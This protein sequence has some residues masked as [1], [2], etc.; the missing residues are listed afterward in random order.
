VGG[1]PQAEILASFTL[2][3]SAATLSVI[4]GVGTP[5]PP[6][7]PA[8]K[9]TP[10]GTFMVH[11]DLPS[12]DYNVRTPPPPPGVPSALAP[13]AVLRVRVEIMGS[14]ILKN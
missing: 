10:V 12:G 8:G 6:P 7:P 3:K 1:R 2:P 13:R 4:V 11:T 9:G 14:I 5:P